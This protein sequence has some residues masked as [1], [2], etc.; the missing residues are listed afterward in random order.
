MP[1][2]QCCGVKKNL[3]FQNRNSLLSPCVP[4]HL[5]FCIRRTALRCTDHSSESQFEVYVWMY[6]TSIAPEGLKS[7]STV[8]TER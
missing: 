3:H 6:Q 4:L 5:P 7:E 2:N 8:T 1:R